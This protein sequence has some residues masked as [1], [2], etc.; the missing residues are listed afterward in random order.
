MEAHVHHGG[1]KES[2]DAVRSHGVRQKEKEKLTMS[3]AY[4]ELEP[5]GDWMPRGG[6]RRTYRG[7]ADKDEW[8]NSYGERD[9]I[10]AQN[11]IRLGKI[12]TSG[13]RK[14]YP[15]VMKHLPDNPTVEQLAAALAY[16]RR[17]FNKY[18]TLR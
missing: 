13:L 12:P 7:S 4:E 1:K 15:R 8:G 17:Y 2:T 3:S 16:H 6:K 9:L 10:V 18:P 14:K 5:R 11:M